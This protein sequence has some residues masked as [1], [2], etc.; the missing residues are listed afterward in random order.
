MAD[1]GKEDLFETLFFL[2]QIFVGLI[3]SF[4][5]ILGIYFGIV[6]DYQHILMSVIL[7]MTTILFFYLNSYRKRQPYKANL[8]WVLGFSNVLLICVAM[9]GYIWDDILC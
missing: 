7:F 4:S 3:V 9:Q 2:G 1:S 8:V 6:N 5:F